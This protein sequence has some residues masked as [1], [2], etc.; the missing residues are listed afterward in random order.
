M[1]GTNFNLPGLQAIPR[2]AAGHRLQWEDVQNAHVLLYPEG[3][4]QLNEAASAILQQ[5]DGKNLAAVIETLQNE[6]GE[7]DLQDDV[8]E[9]VQEAAQR[10]WVRLD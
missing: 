3:M 5:C 10:G 4:V 6:F 9:F 2:L 8:L 1:A 7:T